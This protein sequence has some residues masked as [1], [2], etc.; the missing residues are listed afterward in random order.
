MNSI[1]DVSKKEC[2]EQES[3]NVNC[4]EI[5]EYVNKEHLNSLL[6]MGFG[7]VESEKSLF[8]TRNSGLESAVEWLE[9]NNSD[10]SLK[11]AIVEV[12]TPPNKEAEPEN[13]MEGTKLTD[14]E[15][16][17][18]VQELQKKARE[19]RMNKEKEEEIEK[20]KRRIASTKQLLEAQRKMEES[21]RKR[22]IEMIAKEKDF[23]EKER[24]RQLNLLKM[25]WEERFGCPYPEEQKKEVPKSSKEKV[26]YYCNKMSNMYKSKDIQGITKCFSLLKTY[27]SN[28]LNNPYEE[29]YRKI[30][31][32]NPT[33]ESK[34]LKYEGSLE[35]LMSCGFVKNDNGEFLI[36]P[37][38]K[39]PD[40]FACSQ[41]I[42]FLNLLISTVAE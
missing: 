39:G 27:I 11:D 20:E 21:E 14:E 5:K 4:K 19:I 13:K 15:I 35:L 2:L 34:V 1:Q 8:F 26:G 12:G 31:L 9:E 16:L 36:I 6:S 23:H 10:P 25:E 42:K 24:Q 18:K 41:A 28:V 40:S 7:E 30:R 38:E 22:N 33:F 29:K 3:R 32:S 17:I 37:S